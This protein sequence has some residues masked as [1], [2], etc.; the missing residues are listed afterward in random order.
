MADTAPGVWTILESRSL[1]YEAYYRFAVL[2]VGNL[3]PD[4]LTSYL[5]NAGWDVKSIGGA[6]PEFTAQLPVPTVP[7]AYAPKA[8][9]VHATWRGAN[10]TSPADFGGQYVY[11]PFE[12]WSP[13]E[14]PLSVLPWTLGLM[15]GAAVVFWWLSRSRSLPVHAY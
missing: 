13:S 10:G 9:L 7:F 12:M 15:A 2:A 14:A 11:G 5:T 6:T 4:Q 1:T 8:W 3:S